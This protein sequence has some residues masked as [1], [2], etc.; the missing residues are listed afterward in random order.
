[1]LVRMWEL[2]VSASHAQRSVCP[3]QALLAMPSTAD[4][5]MLTSDLQPRPARGAR[6]VET[7]RLFGGGVAR[8]GA[9]QCLGHLRG[10]W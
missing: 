7:V 9:S 5:G 8:G 1:M 4:V 6:R 2:R 10:V 3:W